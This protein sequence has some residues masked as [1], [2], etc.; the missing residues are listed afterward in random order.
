MLFTVQIKIYNKLN[1]SLHFD[2]NKDFIELIK[3]LP[4]REYK[5]DQKIWV[6]DSLNLYTLISNFKGRKDIFFSFPS[7]AIKTKFIEKVKKSIKKK[8]KEEIKKQEL[9]KKNKFLIEYKKQLKENE[10]KFDFSKYLNENFNLFKHQQVSILWGEE[11]KSFILNLDMGLGKT[12][13]FIGICEISKDV[14]KVLIVC[15]NSLKFDIANDIIKFYK[16]TKYYIINYSKNEYQIDESKYIITNYETF[17]RVKNYKDFI[18][19]FKLDKLD[20]VIFDE[21]HRLK[22]SSSNTYKNIQKLFSYADRKIFSTG[23]PVKSSPQEIFTQL[24]LI[25]PLEFSSKTKFY[26]EF[27]GLKWNSNTR[28][29]DFIEEDLKLNELHEKLQPYI[30]RF[31]KEDALDLPDKIFKKIII[32][33]DDKD[34]KEYER[35]EKGVYIDLMNNEI[36]RNKSPLTILLDLRKYLSFIKLKYI[37]EIIERQIEEGNKVVFVDFF[38]ETLQQLYEINKSIC[39]LHTG[40]QK[41]EERKKSKERFLDK[42]D[43]IKLLAL[44]SSTGKEGLTLTVSNILW[45]NTM[46]WTPADN[47]QIYDR[48]N[49]I[50]QINTCFYFLPIIKNSI[51]ENIFYLNEMKSKIVTKIIDN[52]EY[53]S[54]FEKD[55]LS[56]IF[57]NLKNKYK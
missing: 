54:N 38:K 35:I 48:I 1:Y 43:V 25:N 5:S 42:N 31:K 36:S 41:I 6:L 47:N 13:T 19:K 49:R 57:Q 16:D 8:E 46:E 4:K 39:V 40:D 7:D 44:S 14:K 50:G 11:A 30:I 12:M 22:N 28:T 33:L 32:D 3:K 53:I 10:I 55:L 29:Y 26:E 15:P 51:D 45:L 17:N 23:T 34:R 24:K 9:E 37:Q 20:C 56:N 27:C 52:E 21:S 2:Y 18:K